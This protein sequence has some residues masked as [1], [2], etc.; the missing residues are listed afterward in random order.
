MKKQHIPQL[1]DNERMNWIGICGGSFFFGF[2]I[3]SVIFDGLFNAIHRILMDSNHY[4]LAVQF[5]HLFYY[6]YIFA[7]LIGFLAI[8]LV[9]CIKLVLIHLKSIPDATNEN[10]RDDQI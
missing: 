2:P 7:A 3:G 4:S 10:L 1:R 6:K 8:P 5:D 9:V